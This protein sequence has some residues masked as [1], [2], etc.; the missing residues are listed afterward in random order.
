MT[1]EYCSY[2]IY[3]VAFAKDGKS[4]G[5]LHSR[6]Q[7]GHVLFCLSH[8]IPHCNGFTSSSQ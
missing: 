2:I 6:R 1:T 3:G 4:S 8:L 7:C 5:L